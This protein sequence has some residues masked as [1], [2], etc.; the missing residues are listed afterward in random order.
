M[1][2]DFLNRTP[3]NKSWKLF[4]K[5]QFSFDVK[6]VLD[7]LS[8]SYEE[9]NG[10]LYT[11]CP[12]HK[13]ENPSM[14]F[15]CDMSSGYYG[16]FKCWSCNTIG[17]IID[18][19]SDI[20][21]VSSKEAFDHIEK[22]LKYIDHWT[23]TMNKNIKSFKNNKKNIDLHFTFKPVKK[24]SIFFN[25][26]EHRGISQ[27]VI[28]KFNIMQCSEGFY[29]NRI[30]I[31][32]YHNSK[33]Y[34]FC[35]RSIYK[36]AYIKKHSI[37]KILY[38]KGSYISRVLFPDCV[39]SLNNKKIILVEGIFDALRLYSLG[40]KNVYTTFSN[41]I[42][43]GQRYFLN[44][45]KDIILIPDSDDGGKSFKNIFKNSNITSNL[46][47]YSLPK[48]DDPGSTD[49]INLVNIY[50]KAKICTQFH[51]KILKRKVIND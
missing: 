13:D 17:N 40:Y 37:T 26:L 36:N 28:N 49:K 14:A 10:W 51:R 46:Y 9:R 19:V 4:K 50:D 23:A 21:T 33:L 34:S 25:Y 43:N 44:F 7:N 5:Y 8:I 15:C 39:N 16:M 38:P 12:Y 2:N 35:A 30:I 24:D 42:S 32:I 1:I 48:G 6:S 11:L 27:K 22:N 47:I 3:I 18:L 41:K 45:A 29:N 20:K 31:P